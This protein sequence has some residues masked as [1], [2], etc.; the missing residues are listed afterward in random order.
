M[1]RLRPAMRRRAECMTTASTVA[2]A[3]SGNPA[4]TAP[5]IIPIRYSV[6][7]MAA[8]SQSPPTPPSLAAFILPLCADRADLQQSHRYSRLPHSDYRNDRR[9]EHLPDGGVCNRPGGRRYP[10]GARR[11]PERYGLG[12][13]NNGHC[14]QYSQPGQRRGT[15]VP[16]TVYRQGFTYQNEPMALGFTI[17]A[18]NG[19]ASPI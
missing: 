15:A 16:A 4:G 13:G 17:T 8:S 18:M 14:R 12:G 10:C 6:A 1:H 9:S 2:I 19:A 11:R 7:D 3:A 5:T